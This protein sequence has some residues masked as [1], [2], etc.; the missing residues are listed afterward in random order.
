MSD[1]IKHLVDAT[2]LINVVA[3]LAAILPAIAALMSIIWYGIRIYEYFKS[4]KEV[5]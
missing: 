1:Y 2:A 5:E 3:T 4:G